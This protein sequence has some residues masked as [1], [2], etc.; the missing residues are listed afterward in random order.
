MSEQTQT[1][2]QLISRFSTFQRIEHW[3]LFASFTT[4]A[5][6]GLPQKFPLA[7][8]SDF[9]IGLM[10]GIEVVRTIHRVAATI[11]LLESV[12]H[13]VVAGYK[14]FVMRMKATMVPGASDVT[15]AVQ[16]VLYNL[17]IRR[18]Q[19]RAGRYNFAEKLEYWAMV[20][21]LVMMGATGFILWNPIVSSTVLPGEIIP[22][23]KSAHGYEAVLAV[24]AIIIWHFY[25][26][27]VRHWNWS[28]FNGKQ[29]RQEMEEEHPI[30]LADIES[31]AAAVRPA[32]AAQKKRAS[33]YF[34][35]AGVVVLLLVFGVYKIITVEQTA[36]TT[37]VPID[38]GVAAYV[39]Q[40]PTIIPTQPPTATALPTATQ[41]P[42]STAA[43]LT[44]DSGVGQLFAAS[45]TACH[46]SSGGLKLSNYADA[47]KGG[48][49]GPVI[50]PGDPNASLLVQKMSGNH[51]KTFT[52]DDLARIIAWI[53]AG[54]LEK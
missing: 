8:I 7:G 22:A 35:I 12:Y 28:M 9:M 6:T 32:P 47:M 40:T 30:E 10:G 15:E 41:L 43:P 51:P 13:L 14:L 39:R 50:V 38:N 36:L 31:G 21:G 46:G 26:V 23:A 29:T 25:N 5:L 37:I 16:A 20:W 44:W 24:L 1:K 4:L 49:D 53:Q 33:I 17:G 34:P 3:L 54:A 2:P 11:F 42:G 52:A 27:H 48:Q 45:C 18:E 19:P